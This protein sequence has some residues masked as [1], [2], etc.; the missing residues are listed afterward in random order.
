[1]PGGINRRRFLKGAGIA[2]GLAVP[3]LAAVSSVFSA[4]VCYKR[5]P[6]LLILE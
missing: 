1:M 4:K 3:A 5:Y 2:I 6:F